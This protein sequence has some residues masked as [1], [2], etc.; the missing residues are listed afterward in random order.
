[1]SD[2][3]P[4]AEPAAPQT[5][6]PYPL[7]DEM[8]RLVEEMRAERDGPPKLTWVPH[9]IWN[10]SREDA[11][12]QLAAQQD[13]NATLVLRA[14]VADLLPWLAQQSRQ[15]GEQARQRLQDTLLL[16]PALARVVELRKL[17]KRARLD[18]NAARQKLTA[19]QQHQSDLHRAIPAPPDLAARLVAA[20]ADV[21]AASGEAQRTAREAAAL[22]PLL[23]KARADLE[24][25]GPVLARHQAQAAYHERRA[26]LDGLLKQLLAD[27]GQ[28][29]STLA[30][31]RRFPQALTDADVASVVSQL[32]DAP[33][34][35]D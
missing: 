35:D 27:I 2:T 30:D 25:A 13:G 4:L 12:I 3:I 20:E 16:H 5:P 34:L 29:L 7:M 22:V 14:R 24:S 18:E 11:P 28:R 26:R 31:L 33:D 32:A 17:I 9:G 1:M 21:D 23:S 15:A 10:G 8:T 6:A 19:A